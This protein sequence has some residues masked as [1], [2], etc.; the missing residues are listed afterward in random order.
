MVLC[1]DDKRR[2]KRGMR[3][4]SEAQNE[5]Q[6]FQGVFVVGDSFI[7]RSDFLFSIKVEK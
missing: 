6:G 3:R 1:G 5:M 4:M 7:L 2:S